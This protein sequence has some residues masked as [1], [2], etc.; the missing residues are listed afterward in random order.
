MCWIC[1]P[2]DEVVRFIMA[3]WGGGVE[4]AAEN[5]LRE[6]ADA[7]FDPASVSESGTDYPEESVEEVNEPSTCRGRRCGHG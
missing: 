5:V 6:E 2:I 1:T 3:V 4:N 7:E